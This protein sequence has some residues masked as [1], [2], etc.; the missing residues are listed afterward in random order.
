MGKRFISF[1][2]NLELLISGLLI[3]GLLTVFSGLLI[4][5]E[6]H[7]GNHGNIATN[8]YVF[9]ISYYGWSDIH[10]ISI[11]IFSL[12]IFSHIF[13]H[14]KWYKVVIKKKHVAKNIQVFTLS[15]IFILV[16]ITG[17]IPWFFDLMN[18]DVMLRKAFIEIHDK[19]AIILSVYLILHVIKRLKWFFTTFEKMINKHSTQERV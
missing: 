9:G 14:R 10:K 19:L 5:V 8:D 16:A 13:L 12:L 3:S 2:I 6:Y 18:G 7:I 15:I 17:L 1:I 11:V 4:Q